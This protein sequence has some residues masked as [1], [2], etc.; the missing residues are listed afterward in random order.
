MSRWMMLDIQPIIHVS[1][2]PLH[3]HL[4]HSILLQFTD[5]YFNDN[6]QST[7]GVDFKVKGNLIHSTVWVAWENVNL[8]HPMSLYLGEGDGGCWCWARCQESQGHNLGYRLVGGLVTNGGDVMMMMMMIDEDK[9]D[10]YL[11]PS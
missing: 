9:D 8:I 3:L 7:I 11:H 2:S 1:S 6:L 4:F 10:L 5:D